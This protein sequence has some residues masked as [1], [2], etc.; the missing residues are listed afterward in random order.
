MK[1]ITVQLEDCAQGLFL[2]SC[3]NVDCFFPNRLLDLD[4]HTRVEAK[5]PILLL[6]AKAATFVQG[7]TAAFDDKTGR[8]LA[9][10]FT[11]LPFG[12]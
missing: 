1:S 4:W 12:I 5:G 7:P 8:L 2:F 9:K 3:Y 6:T 10:L 11:F